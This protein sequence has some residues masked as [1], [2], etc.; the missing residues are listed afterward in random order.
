MTEA[1]LD[2]IKALQPGLPGA[3][4]PWLANVR[5][6]AAARFAATGFPGRKDEA[7]KYADLK[8][9]ERTP[10]TANADTDQTVGSLPWLDVAGPRLVFIDGHF[11]V[12]L[13]SGV[14]DAASPLS[15]LLEGETADLQQH[16]AS[17]QD[18]SALAQLNT[19]LAGDGLVLRVPAGEDAGT[20]QLLM[21][22]TGAAANAAAH[23]RNVIHLEAGAKAAIV[24]RSMSFGAEAYWANAVTNIQIEQ[25]AVLQHMHWQSDNASAMATGLTQAVVEAEG[26]YHRFTLSTGAASARSEIRVDVT[27][28]G[29]DVQLSGVQLGKA[30]QVL[31]TVTLLRHEIG[32]ATSNQTYRAVVDEKARTA[33]SGKVYVARDAQKTDAQQS[34]RNLLLARTAEADTKPELE[35]YADDVHCAHGATV[36]ELDKKALFY[37]ASRGVSPEAARAILVQAFVSDVIED[38]AIDAVKEAYLEATHNWLMEQL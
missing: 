23:I 29:A 18:A 8:A 37:L 30:R 32:H 4:L 34:S 28:Q 20:I 5:Q 19:A 14:S 38:I 21:V 7:F 9:L 15:A 36:G 26:A 24:E 27:G 35:I 1:Y 3:Q 2:T 13:S 33:F 17:V 11:H 16:F 12:G 6:A 10:F 22:S 31:D 25:G